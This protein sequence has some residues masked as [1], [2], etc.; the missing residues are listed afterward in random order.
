M[1]EAESGGNTL[2]LKLSNKTVGRAFET[3]GAGKGA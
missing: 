3:Q 2:I 1:E